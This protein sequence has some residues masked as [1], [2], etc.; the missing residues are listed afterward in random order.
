MSE[1]L[2]SKHA[3]GSEVNVDQ[4]LLDGKI[5]AYD[6]LFLNEGKI[7]WINKDGEKVILEDK[8]QILPVSSLPDVGDPEVIYI[9]ESKFY[10]WDGEKYASPECDGVDESTVDAKVASAVSSANA[11]TDG[12][13]EA[14]INE[15]MVK[16][17]EISDVPVGTL[18]DYRENEIRI[19]C[20]VDAVFTKQAVGVGGDANS[21]YVTFK[22]YVF[23]DSVVGYIEHLGDKVDS[24]ILTTFSTDEYGRRY[25]STWLAVA[26]YD[27]STDTWSY[28]GSKSN[29]DKY[30]G[31]DYQIDWYNAEGKMIASD[32]IRIN[33]SNEEC[34]FVN[35]PY[36]IANVIS[37]VDVKIATLEAAY[38]IVEF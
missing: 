38:T 32:N 34:H 27:E 15:H 28:Y 36:Y 14:A 13:V 21:Y 24:E 35:E 26:N 37:D 8:K 11:Y 33:L 30:I 3:F 9:Y 6:I 7:G 1:L 23:D 12:K 4:A 29:K 20:P 22:T 2:R 5:D 16:K 17:F 31:W 18:V 10:F 25:Q 19:M